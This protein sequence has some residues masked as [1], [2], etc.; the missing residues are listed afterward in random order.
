MD[1]VEVPPDDI[2]EYV[3]FE[4]AQP[5]QTKRARKISVMPQAMPFKRDLEVDHAVGLR[6]MKA[7]LNGKAPK[8]W[9]DGAYRI[10]L[11]IL[12]PNELTVLRA[13]LRTKPKPSYF[14]GA[15]VDK[16]WDLYLINGNT[17]SL[18]RTLGVMLAG[19][20]PKVHVINAPVVF[21]EPLLPLLDE[22][23]AKLMFK[24]PQEGH[25]TKFIHDLNEGVRIQ[26]F[27]SALYS[28][29]TGHGK[30]AS[31]VHIAARLG[32]RMLFI[33]HNDSVHN[34]NVDEFRK[35]LGSTLRVG[36]M[37]TSN[38]KAWKDIDAPI[39]QTTHKSAATC[40]LDV[41]GFGTV[42]VDEAH[43][44]SAAVM[45]MLYMKFPC[46]YLVLLTATPSRAGDHCGAYLEWL[47]GPVS[48]Y[49]RINLAKSRW[50][51]VT[52]REVPMIYSKPLV[53]KRDRGNDGRYYIDSAATYTITMYHRARNTAITR[54]ITHCVKTENRHVVAVA[55][56]V[57]HVEVIVKLLRANG[58]DAGALVGTYTDGRTQ[59]EEER[60]AAFK[61]RVLVAYVAL[62]TEALNI[63]RLDTAMQISGGC[64][65]NNETFWIQFI[66]RVMRDKEGKN[67]PL[68]IL[69]NDQSVHGMFERQVSKA[70]K[71]F[72]GIG[73]GFE[74]TTSPNV[75]VC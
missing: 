71:E 50:G 35:F 19:V 7:A 20:P 25:V 17:L 12:N 48:C 5:R 6:L 42:I 67:K 29:P 72:R 13:H 32:Q 10:P 66:G 3:E 75:R 58:I 68:I 46:K 52:V 24:T 2:E 30:T 70:K 62:A 28:I 47:G 21:P 43:K 61:C 74:F 60:A 33:T 69:P 56:R 41:R 4:D 34:L 31:A 55:V 36:K 15:R 22:S 18:P 8:C 51:G 65:W 44:T 54:L 45:K 11:R 9:I 1:E 49:V 63:P 14:R 73:E 39:V 27:G 23:T 37:Q 40:D 59:T 64:P 16:S 38:R 26:G 53:E 57:R